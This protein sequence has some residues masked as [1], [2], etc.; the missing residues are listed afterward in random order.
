MQPQQ[1]NIQRQQEIHIR[2]LEMSLAAS[3]WAPSLYQ[4]NGGMHSSILDMRTHSITQINE[5]CSMLHLVLDS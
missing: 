1:Q 4:E 5:R 2:G 3:S